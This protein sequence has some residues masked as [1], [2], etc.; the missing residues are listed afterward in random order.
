MRLIG[1]ASAWSSS[2]GGEHAKA[3]A[4]KANAA[5][6]AVIG[7]AAGIEAAGQEFETAGRL[8]DMDEVAYH[9]LA[10]GDLPLKCAG[11]EVVQ[12]EMTEAVPL[13]EPDEL[14]ARLEHADI[15]QPQHREI[16][17]DEGCGGL[18]VHLAHGAGRDGQL[19]ERETLPRSG[20]GRERTRGWNRRSSRPRPFRCR[21]SCR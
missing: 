19:E 18:A 21:S 5:E 6:A 17:V 10:A 4:V 14:A 3:G 9:P 15:G 20:P 8:I 11:R 12:I 1:M 16:G 2:P 7:I 13:R